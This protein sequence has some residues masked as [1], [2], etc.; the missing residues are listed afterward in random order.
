VFCGEGDFIGEG[1]DLSGESA[2]ELCLLFGSSGDK[3]N[4]FEDFEKSCI[5][6]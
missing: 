5:E 3:F 2:S 1:G 4:K 6:D